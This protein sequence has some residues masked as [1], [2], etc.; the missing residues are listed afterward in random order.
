MMP[1]H[2]ESASHKKHFYNFTQTLLQHSLPHLPPV[3]NDSGFWSQI[4]TWEGAHANDRVL[5]A[6]DAVPV[7]QG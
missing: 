3:L 4:W 1:G 7:V 5:A 6:L 2:G